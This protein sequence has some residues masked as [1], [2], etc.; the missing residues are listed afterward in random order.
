MNLI[1]MLLMAV[2]MSMDAFAVCLSA[3]ATGAS[4]G[5][6][7]TFRLAFHFGLFQFLMPV[8]GWLAGMSL[9]RYLSTLADWAAFIL[10]ALVGLHM[11]RS[12][13]DA[14][15]GVRT[16][17]LSRGWPLVILSLAT[18]IDALAVGFSLGLI[19]V[20]IWYPA[21]MIGLVTGLVSWLGIV[22]GRQLGVR[23]GKQME[24]LGG[25]IVLGIGVS[26]LL[27]HL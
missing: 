8:L 26:I 12:G 13:F 9:V 6:R 23:L 20:L 24:I 15:S 17:D 25:L 2:S 1:E 21:V 3:G 19:G 5:P 27:P 16:R 22:L 10:L 18:S 14:R 7:S 11:I 4:M